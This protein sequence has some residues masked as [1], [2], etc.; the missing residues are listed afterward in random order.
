M[1][2]SIY[3]SITVWQYLL[4]LV[5]P[6]HRSCLYIQAYKH[7]V[8]LAV[9]LDWSATNNHEHSW[10]PSDIQ[11]LFKPRLLLTINPNCFA[12][13]ALRTLLFD[14]IMHRTDVDWWIGFIYFGGTYHLHDFSQIKPCS[15][16]L[17]SFSAQG[18][19]S[20]SR[21]RCCKLPLKVHSGRKIAVGILP[22]QL[23]LVGS[24]ASSGPTPSRGSLAVSSHRHW[25]LH[26][27][28]VSLKPE[29]FWRTCPTSF[30]PQMR[31]LGTHF[32]GSSVHPSDPAFHHVLP[33]SFVEW[34]LTGIPVVLGDP[35]PHS[36]LQSKAAMMKMI[37]M[38]SPQPKISFNRII[39]ANAAWRWWPS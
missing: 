22:A 9:L 5:H 10:R 38:K 33:A 7:I 35:F 20:P 26:C 30:S 19:A 24:M 39:A 6:C 4:Y 28:L 17:S 3:K 27:P 25:C 31:S 37:P 16:R 12:V 34:W 15:I 11:F 2:L 14:E 21:P 29:A 32:M 8:P 18:F 1:C 36:S 13:S 23:T